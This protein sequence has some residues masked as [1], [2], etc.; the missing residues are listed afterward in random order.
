[1]KNIKT[2]VFALLLA[3]FASFAMASMPEKRLIVDTAF[4]AE[5][6]KRGALLW[7]VRDAESYRKGHILGALNIGSIGSVLRFEHNED[8]L[9]I[10]QIEKIFGDAGIDLSRE[11]VVYGNKAD[12]I[13]YFGL[14]TVQYFGGS[15]VHVYHGGI[16]DWKAARKETAT[17]TPKFAPLTLKLKT[18]PELTVST[19]EVVSKIGTGAQIVD[20][21]S[22]K[23]FSGEDIRAIRGGHIPSAINI[24]FQKNWV[25]PDAHARLIKK[26]AANK[27]GM[28]LKSPEQLKALYA[29]LDPDRE[30][31]VYCQSG[32]RA[33]ESVAVLKDLG[34]K[35]V[36]V[37]DASWLGYANALSTPVENVSVFNVG[38]MNGKLEAMQRRIEAMERVLGEMMRAMK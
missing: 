38:Q 20:A 12:P 33:A 26:E 8:Y 34:F 25:D 18:Q 14:Y 4:V 19:E 1:M 13:V 2:G 15:N 23:E 31:I 27:D 37:Y 29:R 16:D 21:R 22:P 17:E 24:P 7:D 11:I 28:N 32:V 35:N 36:K 3:L 6:Q 5:A 10:E 30:T 9:P